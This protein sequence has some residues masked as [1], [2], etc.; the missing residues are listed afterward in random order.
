MCAMQGLDLR[1]V[2]TEE[3]KPRVK[4]RLVRAFA[5]W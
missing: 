2:V 3:R 4:E 1:D 5:G